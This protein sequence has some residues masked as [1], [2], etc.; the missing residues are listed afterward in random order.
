MVGGVG[1]WLVPHLCDT[2]MHLSLGSRQMIIS[3]F[4]VGGG[5]GQSQRQQSPALNNII[6]VQ[7]QL[8]MTDFAAIWV[9]RFPQNTLDF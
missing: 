2:E 1:D 6:V 5:G 3:S 8:Q 4:G 9:H 7:N